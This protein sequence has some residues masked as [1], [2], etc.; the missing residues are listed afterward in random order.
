MQDSYK[1]LSIGILLLSLAGCAGFSR[2]TYAKVKSNIILCETKESEVRK[3]YGD[4]D[5]IGT[6]FK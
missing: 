5:S 4:P 3:I 1:V 6:Q 2:Y